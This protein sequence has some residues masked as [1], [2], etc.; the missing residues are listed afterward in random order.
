M[1]PTNKKQRDAIESLSDLLKQRRLPNFKPEW[2]A[3]K[4]AEQL[5]K[6][7]RASGVTLE[8]FEGPRYQR[9]GHINKLLAEG[10]LDTNL[11]HRPVGSW[12]ATASAVPQLAGS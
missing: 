6:A 8:E 5:Y 3:K 4:G 7:Y 2:D 11:R 10:I 1:A 9:I 12:N